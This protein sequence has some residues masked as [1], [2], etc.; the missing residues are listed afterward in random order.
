MEYTCCDLCGADSPTFLLERADRFSGQGFRYVKCSQCGLIYV[1]PRPCPADLPSYYPQRYEAYQRLGAMTPVARLRRR[2]AL[3]IQRHFIGR[4]HQSGRLLDVG[5]GTG[6]F[7]KEMQVHG[8]EVQGVEVNERATAVAQEEYNLRIFNGPLTAFQA[9][10]AAFDVVTLWD[11]LEHL[12]AP[13]ASLKKINHLLTEGGHVVFSV[14]NLRSFD[15]RLFGHC[16]IGWDAPRHLHLFSGRVVD[17]LLS[18]TGFE[19]EDERCLLGGPGAFVLSWQSW[20]EERLE[21]DEAKS[22][23]VRFLSALFPYLLW[24]YKELSYAVNRGPVITIV[25]RKTGR[26]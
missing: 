25:A 14:P 1:N 15:A 17:R 13:R 18:E 7:L 23:L 26:S 21:T 3:G 10:E 16:W 11:V 9:G 24:P 6:A 8:W 5:C 12:P 20:L 4:Y 2:H 22:G 19:L